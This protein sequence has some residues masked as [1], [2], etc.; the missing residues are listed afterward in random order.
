M[1]LV[2]WCATVIVGNVVRR[3]GLIAFRSGK[4]LQDM[5]FAACTVGY[6][7]INLCAFKLKSTF[8][9]FV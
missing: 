9:Q 8:F 4:F 7:V 5:W 3:I 1:K 2:V 6:G